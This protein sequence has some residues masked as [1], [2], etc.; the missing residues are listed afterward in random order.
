MA[1]WEKMVAAPE[2]F[3]EWSFQRG[4]YVLASK[5]DGL[6]RK[7]HLFRARAGGAAS[8]KWACPGIQM[9]PRLESFAKGTPTR[10]R[11][12]G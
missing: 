1:K 3:D 10:R 4:A 8:H 6:Y 2:G 7:W 5:W 11:G 9:L 12:R